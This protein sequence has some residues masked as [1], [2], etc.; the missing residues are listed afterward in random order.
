MQHSS[1][2]V[3]PTNVLMLQMLPWAMNMLSTW[4]V[5]KAALAFKLFVEVVNE[6]VFVTN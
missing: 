4:Q 3:Q 5:E 6:D 1:H 2:S